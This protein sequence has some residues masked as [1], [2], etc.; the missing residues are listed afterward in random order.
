M[1][2]IGTVLRGI[3]YA[4]STIGTTV[5]TYF[6]FIRDDMSELRGIQLG[7]DLQPV[8]AAL[9]VLTITTSVLYYYLKTKST[10][11]A[12]QQRCTRLENILMTAHLLDRA[13]LEVIADNGN[14]RDYMYSHFEKSDLRTF[15]KGDP[16]TKHLSEEAIEE[17]IET[18]YDKFTKKF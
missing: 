5:I 1:K 3:W 9:V 12:L 16:D 7:F 15:L 8:L 10:C 14:L 4:I 18:F 6:L 11:A 17:I 2:N 13:R